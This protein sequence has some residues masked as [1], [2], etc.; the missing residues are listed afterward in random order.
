MNLPIVQDW[1]CAKT[2]D[3]CKTG[4]LV[5]THQEWALLATVRPGVS[6]RPHD[7]DPGRFVVLDGTP[8][9]F[10]GADN[11]C[12]VY[13]VRPTNCRRF[14]CQRA[15]GEPF[16]SGGPLGCLNLSIR[17]VKSRKVRRAYEQNQRKAHKWAVQHGWGP[18]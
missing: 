11:L 13:D 2:G 16:L 12:T 14:M 17:V 6:V 15:P 5:M 1:A 10:L 4:S 9:P 7:D 18:S 3:C 8:C